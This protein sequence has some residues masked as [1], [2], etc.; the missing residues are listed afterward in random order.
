MSV[1]DM[2][3]D[4]EKPADAELTMGEAA[5]QISDKRSQSVDSSDLVVRVK[6]DGEEQAVPVNELAKG[7]MRQADYTKKTQELADS[8]KSLQ[9]ERDEIGQ[10][11]AREQ[12]RL[13]ALDALLGDDGN[14]LLE[15]MGF[16]SDQ[17][18]AWQTHRHQLHQE[19]AA[20]KLDGLKERLQQEART[21]KEKMPELADAGARQAL[22]GYLKTQ[23][24][25]G[26]E[27][28]NLI[29]H[30]ALMV[31]DKARRYDELMARKE[32]VLKPQAKAATLQKA[33]GQ[34]SADSAQAESR[35]K[36]FEKLRQSGSLKDAARLIESR[37]R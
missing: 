21:L 4:T 9:Q 18:A 36:A 1:D 7:Y 16:S 8:R 30:R 35:K 2:K 19:S 23:G 22:A 13:A 17:R 28:S 25:S 33:Q 20:K 5:Q 34:G 26:E 10:L 6:L 32:T 27:L 3:A 37:Y 12:E 15:A 31:A 29:D 11:R 24:Y 14:G